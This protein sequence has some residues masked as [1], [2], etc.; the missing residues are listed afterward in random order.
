MPVRKKSLLPPRLSLSVLMS[1]IGLSAQ[2]GMRKK[3]LNESLGRRQPF[4][5]NIPLRRISLTVVRI[6]G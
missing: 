1:A 3:T 2:L 4:C 6:W 5:Q